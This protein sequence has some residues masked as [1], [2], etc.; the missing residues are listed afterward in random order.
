VHFRTEEIRIISGRGG[1][2]RENKVYDNLF[3]NTGE[4][5]VNF[6]NEHNTADGNLYAS[7][8]GGYLQIR[9]P[10]RA[11]LLDVAAA[12]DYY[13]WEKNGRS[14]SAQVSLDPDTLKLTFS[15]NGD[16][17][18]VPTFNGASITND[19]FGTATGDSRVPGAFA[20][21]TAMTAKDVD[22]RRK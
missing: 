20:D 15:V 12:R 4:S 19:F 7:V 9:R 1:L 22:P 17:P 11:E 5:A 6:E 8:P 16:V 21:L 3:V 2:S 10:G 14:G 13:G 18:K